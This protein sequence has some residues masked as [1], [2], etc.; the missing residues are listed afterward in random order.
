MEEYDYYK[1]IVSP[2]SCNTPAGL[3]GMIIQADECESSRFIYRACANPYAEVS[4]EMVIED[5]VPGNRYL[6]YIDGYDGTQ[7]VFN[8]KLEGS[9]ANPQSTEDIRRLQNDYGNPP[10]LFEPD[11]YRT[12][13]LNNESTIYWSAPASEDVDIFL[14]E[15]YIET[16]ITSYGRVIGTVEPMAVVAMDET[17]VYSFT[18]R[19]PF[20][21]EEKCCY[22]IVK[23]NSQ[24]KKSYSEPICL[25]ANLT[26]DFYIS[27]VEYTGEPGFYYINFRNYKKQDLVFSI[28][29]RNEEILKQMT[30]EKE[31]KRDGQIRIDMN[32]YETGVYFLKVEGKSEYY[33]RRFTVK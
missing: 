14:I 28:L 29:D 9:Q 10:P 22:R 26:E 30:R 18:D 8:L 7:C 21:D 19:R 13:F 17:P 24:G 31:P 25:I 11:N 6:I 32:P 20:T 12:E 2:L 1:V 3:Q 33:L 27:P 4:F 15:K 23:V 5:S 16:P